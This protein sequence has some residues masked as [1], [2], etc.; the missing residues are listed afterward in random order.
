MKVSPLVAIA[1]PTRLIN[2]FARPARAVH[3]NA[4]I[5]AVFPFFASE[6][7]F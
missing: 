6:R 5:S 3:T 1:W 4:K 7:K 2:A